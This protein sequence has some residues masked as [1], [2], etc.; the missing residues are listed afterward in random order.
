MCVAIFQWAGKHT[1][2]INRIK[3]TLKTRTELLVDFCRI[4]LSA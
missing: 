4:F 3:I 1:V 2:M